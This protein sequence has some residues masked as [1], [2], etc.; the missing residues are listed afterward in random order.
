[1]PKQTLIQ[2]LAR[3]KERQSPIRPKSKLYLAASGD[4]DDYIYGAEQKKS[5]K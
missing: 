3:E 5:E 4:I 1:M 2:K